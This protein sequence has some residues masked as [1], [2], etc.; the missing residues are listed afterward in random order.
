MARQ[1]NKKIEKQSSGKKKD[2]LVE[3]SETSPA[4]TQDTRQ[5]NDTHPKKSSVEDTYAELTVD[6]NATS[7]AEKKKKEKEQKGP[8]RT[9]SLGDFKLVKKLGQGGMGTVYLA[10]QMTLDRDVALKI[11]SKKLA[12]RADFVSRFLR[13]AR[14]M[15]KL[16][17]PNI[18]QVYAADSVAGYYYVALEFIDGQSMQD[19]MDQVKQLSVA[20]A[21]YTVLICADALKVAHDQNMIHRDIKPDNILVTKTGIVKVADFGLAKVIDDDTSVTQS[22]TGLGTPLFMAPE[23]ARNAKHVDHRTDIYAL[24]ATLYYFLTGKHAFDGENTLEVIMAKEKGDFLPARKLNKKVSER[25]DLIIDKTLSVK[26]EYRYSSCDELIRD[27]EKLALAG[28]TLSLVGA[29]SPP[30]G[31]RR[32]PTRT[33]MVSTPPPKKRAVARTSAEDAALNTAKK[34]VAGEIKCG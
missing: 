12:I 9:N 24:G 32:I 6:P 34:K 30:A 1:K 8:Q 11:L 7:H 17:H 21:L 18:V 33:G 23:Q 26:P 27:L 28:E 14:S 15:A 3:T 31:S 29:I 20:D 25:L 22:G 13:E 2:S 16:Q 19:W 4:E 10:K 5:R